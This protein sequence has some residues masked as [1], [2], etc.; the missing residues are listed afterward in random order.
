MI[1]HI[2]ENLAT[3]VVISGLAGLFIWGILQALQATKV[4][5]IAFNTE[6]K[7]LS[8]NKNVL[9]GD[10]IDKML[11]RYGECND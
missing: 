4:H 5:Y 9:S 2:K 10:Y 6:A 3:I 8:I 7:V 11:D 1:K